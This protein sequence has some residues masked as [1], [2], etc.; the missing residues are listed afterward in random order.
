MLGAIIGDTVG[1]V[2]E[3]DNIKTKDFEFLTEM[4]EFTDDS[5]MTVAVAKAI[6]NCKGDY[7]DFENQLIDCMKY[8][9]KHYPNAGYGGTF[10]RW[11]LGNNREPYNSWG[12]GSA[13]R[14]SPCGFAANSLEEAEAL[15]ERSAAVTHNH[16]E[17]IKGAKAV[18]AAIYL[19]RAGKTQDEIK[20][21]ITDNYYKIDFTLDEIRPFYSF[22]VSCMGSVPQALQ[23][24]FE[25][26]DFEDAVRNCI[27]IGGDCD[28]TAAM[29]GAIAE[30]YF[31]IPEKFKDQIDYFLTDEMKEVVND[32]TAEFMSK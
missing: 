1:S 4:N 13:M 19:A 15:A 25:A 27:S 18:A 16:P 20:K 32:F 8:Y 7:S 31:G 2:Y 14:V 21:Y 9:G 12:N 23:C 17:G 26:T 10:Y 11:V 24:F 6:L 5:V 28:T 29:A 30:A 22:D 3:F